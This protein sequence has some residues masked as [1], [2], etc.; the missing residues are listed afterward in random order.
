MTIVLLTSFNPC[1]AQQYVGDFIVIHDP[2]DN[3]AN[4]RKEADSKS[5]I[6]KKLKNGAVIFCHEEQGDWMQVEDL[7]QSKPLSGYIHKSL[8]KKLTSFTQ[9]KS[10]INKNNAV[11]TGKNLTVEIVAE[12]FQKAEH[13]YTFYQDNKDIVSTIDGS[14]FWGADGGYPRVQ[15]KSVTLKFGNKT[16]QLPKQALEHLYEPNFDFTGVYYD[17]KNDR[18]YITASN[19]DGAGGYCFAWIIE[20]KKYKERVV[21]I[22]S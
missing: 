21:A 4:I 15:Y 22:G 2:N 11:F 3:Y 18:I 9:L 6:I 14:K 12:P 1:V 5:K 19:S 7:E 20:N 16:Y 17:S 10:E 8:V 13:K